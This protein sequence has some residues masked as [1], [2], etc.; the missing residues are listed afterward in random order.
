MSQTAEQQETAAATE[1]AEKRWLAAARARCAEIT[2]ELYPEV[3]HTADPAYRSWQ[4]EDAPT[5]I[6]RAEP[7]MTYDTEHKR[8]VNAT[9]QEQF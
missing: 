8:W 3:R 6:T 4:A 5:E 7:N 1:A 2:K 9:P